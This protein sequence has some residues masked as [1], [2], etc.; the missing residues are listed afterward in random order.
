MQ[1]A[2][3]G[4]RYCLDVSVWPIPYGTRISWDFSLRKLQGQ[5]S[6]AQFQG[7]RLL[8]LG[9]WDWSSWDKNTWNRKSRSMPN[10]VLVPQSLFWDSQKQVDQIRLKFQ[11]WKVFTFSIQPSMSLNPIYDHW[12]IS[13]RYIIISKFISKSIYQLTRN[14]NKDLSCF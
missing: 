1:G 6:L 7:Q 5:I 13:V 10:R 2:A 12:Q 4:L 8:G 9:L 11:F 14:K 3:I